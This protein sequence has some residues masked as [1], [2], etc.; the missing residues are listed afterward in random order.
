MVSEAGF[1]R[2]GA[3]WKLIYHAA[4]AGGVGRVGLSPGAR[5]T[6]EVI[7]GK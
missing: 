3:R 4:E 5:C 7:N 6:P 2:G 1:F